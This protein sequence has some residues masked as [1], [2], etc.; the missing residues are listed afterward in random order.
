MDV[1]SLVPWNVCDR[2]GADFDVKANIKEMEKYEIIQ[3]KL[4][5]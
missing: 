3:M 4:R 1:A 5:Y 2:C